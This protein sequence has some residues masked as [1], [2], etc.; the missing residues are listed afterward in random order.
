MPTVRTRPVPLAPPRYVVAGD[1]G[2]YM[3]RERATL[4]KVAGPYSWETAVRV[5]ADRNEEDACG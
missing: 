4:R 3:I 5:C 2:R 1:R